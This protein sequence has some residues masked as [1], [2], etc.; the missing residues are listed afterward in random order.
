MGPFFHP[1]KGSY[2][3]QGGSTW[4][5]PPA[6]GL[7]NG[8]SLREKKTQKKKKTHVIWKNQAGPEWSQGS[9]TVPGVWSPPS[10][11]YQ[12]PYSISST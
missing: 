10:A 1:P 8:T 12:F 11:P 6:K 4:G 2:G 7:G 5:G 9:G 3:G